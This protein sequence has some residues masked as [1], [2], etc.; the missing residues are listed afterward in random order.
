MDA[1]PTPCV[2]RDSGRAFVAM[3]VIGA[4]CYPAIV[5]TLL[6]CT[7]WFPREV[8]LWAP[9]SDPA[10]RYATG[11]SLGTSLAAGV[12]ALALATPCGYVLSRY[13]FPGWRLVDILLYLPIVMPGLVIGVSLLIFFRTPMGRFIEEHIATF[14]F[15]IPGII[16][17]QTV[18][19]A[20]FATRLAKLAFDGASRR[21]AGVAQTLGASRWQA[22]L[23]VEF[24]EARWGLLEAFV[25]AWASAFGA[26]GPIILF[27]GT[28]R[29]R[30]EV[31]STSV[32]LEF[33]IGNLDRA[34]V[35]SIWMGGL[36]ALV[37]LLTRALGKRTVW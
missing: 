17:A 2:R 19:G 33:S 14:T 6:F 8:T 5:A 12:V 36:A 21:R 15:A 24:A 26:F 23:H 13:R 25:L 18:V 16:L 34:L 10:I 28:T 29:Q 4:A 7:A 22:F 11:L 3:A 20:A 30:T 1:S 32:F 37:L 35:L 31:L 27:C 9:W